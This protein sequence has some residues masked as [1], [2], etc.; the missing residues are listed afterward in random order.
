MNAEAKRAEFIN[1]QEYKEHPEL[2]GDVVLARSSVKKVKDMIHSD[3]FKEYPHLFTPQ[4]LAHSSIEG[5]KKLIHSDEFIKYNYL[6]T[7]SVL[8]HSSI[9]KVQ[10]LI[11]SDEFKT[12]NN[13]FTPTVL[14]LSTIEDI[15][16]LLSLDFWQ[17]K[18]FKNILSPMVLAHSRVMFKKMPVL[19]K[20]AEKYG[21]DGSLTTSCFM[22]SPSQFYAIINHLIEIGQR[23]GITAPLFKEGNLH[24]FFT[25]TSTQLKERFNIDLKELIK[26]YPFD[27]E[28]FLAE[29]ESKRCHSMK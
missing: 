1:S 16:K 15:K 10:K 29:E 18:R 4:V 2:F 5:V 28:K 17:D 7:S 19:I 21:I 8:G 22:K 23:E 20:L 11:Q 12:Y 6:F 3:E 27:E 24:P 26:M 9:E 13:L 14:A 25:Y